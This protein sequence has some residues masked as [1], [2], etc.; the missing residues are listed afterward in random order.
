MTHPKCKKD[1]LVLP[2]TEF[3]F[4]LSHF[5]HT[6]TRQRYNFFMMLGDLGGFNGAIIAF[7]AFLMAFYT[8]KGFQTQISEHTPVRKDRAKRGKKYHS[9]KEAYDLRQ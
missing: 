9:V 3:S 5:R 1:C 8:N 2:K 7:P 6:Y 4:Q